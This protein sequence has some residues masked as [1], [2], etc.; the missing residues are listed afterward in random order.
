MIL[1]FKTLIS[2]SKNIEAWWDFPKFDDK[3]VFGK[4]GKIGRIGAFNG[5]NGK[6]KNLAKNRNFSGQ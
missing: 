4:S 6:T 5:N 2:G 3:N 1:T